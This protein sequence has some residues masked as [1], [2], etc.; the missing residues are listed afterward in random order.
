MV[1]TMSNW[2]PAMSLRVPKRSSP[3]GPISSSGTWKRYRSMSLSCSGLATSI[4]APLKALTGVR[5]RLCTPYG[6]SYPA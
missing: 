1:G 2:V 5:Q 6:G 3:P 4:V